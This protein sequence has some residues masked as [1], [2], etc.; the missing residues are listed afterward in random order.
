MLFGSAASIKT[1]R[2]T[3]RIIKGSKLAPLPEEEM[4]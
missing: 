3:N 2:L 1:A 4:R